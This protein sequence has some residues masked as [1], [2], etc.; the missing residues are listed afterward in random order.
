MVYLFFAEALSTGSVEQVVPERKRENQLT[1][2]LL[3]MEQ[4]ASNYTKLTIPNQ[5]LNTDDQYD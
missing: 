4:W 1:Y 5:D 3:Q 2:M